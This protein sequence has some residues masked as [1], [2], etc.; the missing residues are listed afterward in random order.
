MEKE[1]II[2]ENKVKTFKF[3]KKNRREKEAI[4]QYFSEQYTR[5]WNNSKS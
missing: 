3:T 4:S 5:N 2:C 1:Q